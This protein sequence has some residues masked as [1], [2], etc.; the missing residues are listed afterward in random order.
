MA[1]DDPEIAPT[2]TFRPAGIKVDD[3][4]IA[5]YK[6]GHLDQAIPKSRGKAPALLPPAPRTPA[7]TTSL[8]SR[9][10]D[11]LEKEG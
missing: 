3:K 10:R 4:V 7:P 6:S 8:S 11:T 5:D 2:V 9:L 1:H